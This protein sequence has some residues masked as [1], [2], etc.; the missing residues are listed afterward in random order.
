MVC[1]LCDPSTKYMFIGA[2]APGARTPGDPG[3]KNRSK[4]S[5]FF[6][7]FFSAHPGA[8]ILRR[9]ACENAEGCHRSHLYSY[10]NGICM[11][12][13]VHGTSSA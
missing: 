9:K 4:P 13:R 6:F 1:T 8:M 10:D 11:F 5:L 2:I 7:F 3:T 12:R